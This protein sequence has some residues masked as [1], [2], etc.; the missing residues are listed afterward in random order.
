M[1]PAIKLAKDAG[2]VPACEIEEGT[3]AGVILRVAKR[4]AASLIVLADVEQWTWARLLFGPTI[5]EQVTRA[6]DCHVMV[7]RT[8]PGSRFTNY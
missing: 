7:V 6:A 4:C 3:P 5:T 2:V 1:E 8:S